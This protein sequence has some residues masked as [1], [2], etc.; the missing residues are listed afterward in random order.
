VRLRAHLVTL[1][2]A[3]G[4]PLVA[5]AVIAVTLFTRH[6]RA[7]V[8]RGSIETARALVAAVDRELMGSI[9]ALQALGASRRLDTG[10]LP[11]FYED[12]SRVRAEQSQWRT[13]RLAA[14]S[15]VQLL[16]LRHPLG[17][18]PGPIV[19]PRS[20]E[21][22]LRLGRPAVG[23]LVRDRITGTYDVRVRVPVSGA[24][25]LRYVLTAVVDPAAIDQILRRQRLSGDWIGS[26]LD[27]NGVHVARNR[28]TDRFFARPASPDLRA[29]LARGGEG[30][31]RGTTLEGLPV[32]AAFSRSEWSGWTVAFGLPDAVVEAPLRRSLLTLVAG[33]ALFVALGVG[34]ALLVGR[35]IARPIRVLASSA[36]TLGRGEP[37]PPHPAS[38]LD[39]VDVVSRAIEQAG[40]ARR[41]AQQ[42]LEETSETLRALV[43]S[44]ALGLVVTDLDGVVRV[45]N[46]AA[47]AML[48]WRRDEVI[49]GL[50]PHVGPENVAE[51]RENFAPALRGE[52]V[53]LEVRRARKDGSPIDL[54]VAIAP[55]RD[56]AGLT[57]GVVSAFADITEQKR[58]QE[59]LRQSE[60]LIRAVLDGIDDAVFLKD[61]DGRYLVVNPAGC[62][63]I[64]R[65]LEEIL[66][67]DD[68]E[69]FEPETAHR[70]RDRD[71]VVMETGETVRSELTLRVGGV[72]RTYLSTKSARRDPHGRVIGIISIS[73]DA[74]E[75]KQ[76]E[77]EREVLLTRE[78]A[79]RGEAER[80]RQEA[81]VV[82]ELARG[83][84]ASL[85]LDTILLSVAEAARRLCDSDVA[86]IALVDPAGD[87]MVLRYSTGGPTVMPSGFR[88][89]HGK[90]I[91]GVAWA[92]GRPVDP[93][94]L[95]R[96]LA[97]SGAGRS[98]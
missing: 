79:A 40:I 65:P 88:I 44:S 36:E 15:Q 87:A 76:A 29:A 62:R 49:G 89:G 71:R 53:R 95:Q 31:Y 94:A 41:D 25:R 85:D 69:L 93:D 81:E 9:S 64:G 4:L 11:R 50:P 45:W 77:E 67:R 47:E 56:G 86:R 19:E 26:I 83:I 52:I 73:H 18:P 70:I 8:E 82:A 30:S 51:F 24:G 14:P 72:I 38:G 63:A 48:G 75:R 34:L 42:A 20:F 58:A 5:F 97:A 60:R 37:L 21:E 78:Q 96:V 55:L 10:D 1:V 32:F 74:T 2:L 84:N 12:A 98:G 33:G 66:G 23:D 3:T 68:M 54:D 59:A 35:R 27:R 80:R 90:G 28:A 16:D 39:E 13:V 46:P 91:G 57:R 6:E 17:E 43:E 92:T 22:V 7:A 61:R